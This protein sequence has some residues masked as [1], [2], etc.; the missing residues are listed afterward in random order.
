LQSR[1]IAEHEDDISFGS[2]QAQMPAAGTKGV[3]TKESLTG[4][5]KTSVTDESLETNEFSRLPH[6]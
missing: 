4:Q 1:S 5:F 3:D 2:L 6:V